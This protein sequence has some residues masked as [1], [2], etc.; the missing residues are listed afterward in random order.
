LTLAIPMADCDIFREQLAIKYPLYGHA[1]W[2]PSP[3]HPDKP[4]QVG[5]VGFIRKGKFHRLFLLN[6]LLPANDPSH[7]PKKLPDP[8]EDSRKAED[9][10][11][12][13]SKP[14]STKFKE[15]MP[16]PTVLYLL[17]TKS[18]TRSRKTKRKPASFLA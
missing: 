17:L 18:W 16:R 7:A 4:L 15:K 3:R 2:E 9:K 1:L 14:K 8:T 11:K 5:D 12:S 13:S 6:V 10:P